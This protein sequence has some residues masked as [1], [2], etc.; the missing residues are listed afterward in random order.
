M[1]RR[2]SNDAV[3]EVIVHSPHGLAAIAG[4]HGDEL[5]NALKPH[6]VP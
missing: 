6:G 3:N 5:V 4:P 1:I 2:I